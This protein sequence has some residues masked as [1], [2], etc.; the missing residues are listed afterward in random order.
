MEGLFGH[1]ILGFGAV[2]T[3]KGLFMIIIGVI[4]GILIGATPGMSPSMGV[5]LLVPFSYGM[6]P[7][8]AFILFVSVYQ[9][10]NYGGS[11]TAVAINTPGTPSAVVTA[12]DGYKLT[13]KGKPGKGLGAALIS[14][15]FGGFLGTIILMFFSIPLAQAGLKFGPAE[16]FSLAFFGLTTVSSL[17]GSN[18]VKAFISVA[19]GL[20]ISTIGMDPISGYSRFDF[21]IVNLFDGFALI[22]S[23]IGLF[24]LGEIFLSIEKYST[25]VQKAV[26][27]FSSKLPNLK[28]LWGIKNI[29][30]KSSLLGTTIGII[31]GAGATIATFISYSEAKRT[32]KHPELFG[33]GII[34]GV[35]ASEAANSSS[36]GGALVPLLSLGIPGSATTAVLIGALMLH[37]LVP[38]PELFQKNPQI[39]YGIF[40]SLIFANLFILIFG[41]LGNKL[42][43]KIISFPKSLIY[44]LILGI[45]VL[46]S[47]SVKNSLF[48]VWTCLGFGVIGWLFKKYKFPVAPVVLGMVLG[49]LMENS[50]RQAML[51]NGLLTFAKSP[52]SIVLLSLSALLFLKPFIDA[53]KKKKAQNIK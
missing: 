5:A 10:A 4:L 34:D 31:P 46:G 42:W 17:G 27:M 52:I 49:G 12:I 3:L 13:E 7:V 11:I 8:A 24:A 19:F 51:M 6:S 18:W 21:G 43:L 9:A 41:L 15:V 2:L 29:I 22:P 48:D 38:G 28:E 35:A 1:I 25:G 40:A 50:F 23:M 39:P 45:S 32:S 30:L 37:G 14:S 36:V 20:L 33:T 26:K 44:P 16:Y 47:Y 53:K